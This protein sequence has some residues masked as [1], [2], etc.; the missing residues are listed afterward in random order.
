M[1]AA[2]RGHLLAIGFA[3]SVLCCSWSDVEAAAPTSASATTKKKSGK[4]AKTTSKAT[5][6]RLGVV[7][8]I[9]ADPR[10]AQVDQ[11]AERDRLTARIATLKQEIAAGER[12]RTGAAAALA[13]A[14]RALI[15]VTRKLDDLAARQRL[16]Q[17]RAAGLERQR[18]TTDR[19]IAS[20]QSAYAR[21]AQM[22][23]ANQAR[24]PLH[25]YLT[26]GDPAIAMRDDVYFGY[27]ARAQTSDLASL[28]T[29]SDDLLAERRRVDEDSQK[30]A[31]QA[32]AQKS[33]QEALA[34]DQAS[35]RQTLAQ[36]SR[37]LAAQRDTAAALEADEKRL[38]RVVEQLQK[39]IDRQAAEDRARR[40]TAR[41]AADA[42]AAAAAKKGRTPSS[43]D[44]AKTP[45]PTPQTNT[46]LP[47]ETAGRGAFALLRGQLRLPS[48]G[49]IAG[50]FGAP[51]GGGGATWKGVFVKTETRAEVHAVAA[52]KVV[53]ADDL[54][55]F[56][57]LLIVDHGDQYLSI[58]GNNEIL[59]KKAGDS[60]KAGEVISR[61]GDSS[62]DDQTGL[63]FELRFQ[64]RPFDPLSW[65]GGR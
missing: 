9:P 48:R 49:V 60:V 23:Y 47:D 8:T 27:L 61:T 43:R 14:Q 31:T 59:L 37:Q 41:R 16:A 1:R 55:G 65:T 26:G 51:R 56:G 7:P 40:E 13:R 3:T 12:S 11:S 34:A 28:R 54:R 5:A 29:R 6:A 20:S 36:L 58:Y 45:E 19:Q 38:S 2:C 10:Q 52:G 64:G 25:V 32:D 50:R 39:V 63:Y 57:N 24:D 42:A 35:Q 62:G 15:E 53:F 30:L 22:L 44:P 17:E 33:A 21:T 18:T 46:E 4:S